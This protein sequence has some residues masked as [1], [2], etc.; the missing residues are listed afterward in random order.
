MNSSRERGEEGKTDEVLSSCLNGTNMA[1]K[2]AN[3]TEPIGL[4]ILKN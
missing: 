1:A 2:K 4:K 3:S